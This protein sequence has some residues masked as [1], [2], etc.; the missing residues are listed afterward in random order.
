[1]SEP[2]S[3]KGDTVLLISA[4]RPDILTEAYRWFPYSVQENVRIMAEIMSRPLPFVSF[5][6]N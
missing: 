5:P 1:M 4:L 2:V 3:C 6:I